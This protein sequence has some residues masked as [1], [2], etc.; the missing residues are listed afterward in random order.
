MK[1]NKTVKMLLLSFSLILLGNILVTQRESFTAPDMKPLGKGNVAALNRVYQQWQKDY[2]AHGGDQFLTIPLRYSKGFADVR[3]AK[4]ESEIKIDLYTGEYTLL[5]KG[6]PE[7]NYYLWLA[8]RSKR[9]TENYISKNLGR[10]TAFGDG[11]RLASTLDRTEMQAM[12]LSRML[13]TRDAQQPLGN[14]L[15]AGSPSLFQKMF[16]HNEYWMAAA[17]EPSTQTITAPKET[18]FFIKQLLPKAAYADTSERS[19]NAIFSGQIAKGR[20][21]F[22]NETFGGNGRTCS[23]CHRLDNNHTIDPKYIAQLPDDDPLFVAETNPELAALERPK[24]LRQFGLILA[25]LDG[26]DKQG[27]MRSV[28]HLLALGTSITPE[29]EFE[30]TVVEHSLGWSADGSPGTGS[31]REFTIGA[32]IQH[33]P[34]TLNREEGVDFRMPRDEELDA[35]EAYMLSLGRSEELDL[36][37]MYFSSPIVQ[38]GR[39]LF[40]SKEPGT[41]QCKGCH[42]NAGANSSTSLQ[43]GN[44]DTGVE[45]MPDSL[46]KLVWSET[47]EDGGFG[48]DE[49][50][51]CGWTDRGTCYGNREFNMTTVVEAAD[52][53]PFF[54]NNSVNTIEEAVAFYNSNAFHKSP[55]ATPADPNDPDS[56]CERCIHLE[57]TQVTAIA[58]FLRTINAMENIRSSNDLDS[59][60]QGARREQRKE[61]VRLAIAETQDA[62]EV[63]EGG[64]II[65]NPESVRLLRSALAYEQRAL[66]SRYK[67]L[68]ESLIA[69]AIELKQQANDLLLTDGSVGED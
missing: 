5:A 37:A 24:L 69:Q 10:L 41:G 29:A 2:Q 53:G 65:P 54:H 13:I 19:L 56:V 18:D 3:A 17:L 61:L 63:L 59:Q 64:A 34:K 67:K 26:F 62:I 68:A 36:D 8:G 11:Y 39:E 38:K 31:L 28:P 50:S 51:D 6:L 4:S 43:N 42:L 48:Q 66:N 14:V 58:L 22:I 44:R 52:T 21:L 25:N 9:N 7:G 32:V 15:Q 12:Y 35:L 33:M 30:G 1:K 49:R 40:H 55:G 46:L 20:D 27:V 60:A 16:Y 57:P 47:P 23:T 45:N